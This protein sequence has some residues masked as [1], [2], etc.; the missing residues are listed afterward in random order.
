MSWG[1]SRGLWLWAVNSVV[2]AELWALWRWGVVVHWVGLALTVIV[3]EGVVVT[4]FTVG[5]ALVDGLTSAILV[6][7]LFSSRLDLGGIGSEEKKGGSRYEF[8]FSFSVAL[9]FNFENF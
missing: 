8:H 2:F 4:L 9:I 6:W 7:A 3:A 1:S 5:A